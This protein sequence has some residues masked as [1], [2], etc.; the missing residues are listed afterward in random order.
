MTAEL[1]FTDVKVLLLPPLLIPTL[2]VPLVLLNSHYIRYHVCLGSS[3]QCGG[4][5]GRRRAVHDAEPRDRAGDARGHESGHRQ[6]MV[7]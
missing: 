6:K 7:R 2:T 1:L 3:G 4:H 5:R